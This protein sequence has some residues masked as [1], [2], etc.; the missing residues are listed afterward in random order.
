MRTRAT[1]HSLVCWLSLKIWE[2][3]KLV[4]KIRQN[5]VYNGRLGRY[6]TYV[7]GEIL[8]VMIGI[9][10]ALQVNNWNE[11]RK[12]RIIE[13]E[14]LEGLQGEMLANRDQIIEAI[15]AH[16]KNLAASGKL[17]ELFGQDPSENSE[18]FIDSLFAELT[19]SWTYNPRIG[20]L[21][22]IIMSGQLDYIQDEKLK[23]Y[24]ASFQDEAVDASELNLKYIRLKDTRLDPLVDELVS[25]RN[26]YRLWFDDFPSSSRPF[27]SNYKAVFNSLEIENVISTMWAY[28][29]FGLL[30]EENHL[31]SINEILNLI[32]ERLAD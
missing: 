11:E 14:F 19:T 20:K 9:L 3:V 24:L 23:S 12:E 16:K 21:N 26:K 17:I 30:E 28:Q 25:R 27:H 4:R 8:L 2:M 29:K 32:T 13:L 10:L 15:K 22:S 7:I 1:A 18:L 6:L 5:L 31:D